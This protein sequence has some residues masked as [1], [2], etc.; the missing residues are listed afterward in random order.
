MS[1]DVHA[2]V[3][4]GD[5]VYT[6]TLFPK[7]YRVSPRSNPKVSFRLVRA[8]GFDGVDPDGIE[9]GECFWTQ[10]NFAPHYLFFR[11]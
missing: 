2:L 1:F 3:K 7:K 5:D 11:D 4:N 6:E 10:S 9:G 8:P